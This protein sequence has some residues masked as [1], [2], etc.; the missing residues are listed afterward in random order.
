MNP[1]ALMPAEPHD[2][3]NVIRLDRTDTEAPI[4]HILDVGLYMLVADIAKLLQLELV[5]QEPAKSFIRLQV[6][7]PGLIAALPI[8]LVYLPDL[9]LQIFI[10][11]HDLPPSILLRLKIGR[12]SPAGTELPFLAFLYISIPAKYC[13]ELESNCNPCLSLSLSF[14]KIETDK[15]ICNS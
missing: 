11:P 4:L 6:S 9:S 2:L 1:H 13:T 7:L 15:P 3:G 12:T 10:Y 14:V 8:V 5:S